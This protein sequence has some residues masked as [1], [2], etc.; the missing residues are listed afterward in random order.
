MHELVANLHMHTRYSDGQLT[1]REIAQAALRSGLDV[2]VVTDHNVWVQ[3]PEDIY[4]DGERKVLLLV[5]EEIHN[6]ALNPQKNHLLVIGAEREL[7]TYA[8]T[9][10]ALLEAVNKANGLSF[11]AHLY[12]PAAPLFGE[13]DI[14]WVDWNIQG[15]TGI[16]LWNG[17]SEFKSL[18]KSRLH[19]LYY[20]YN[21]QRV[22]HA[23]ATQALQRWDELLQQGRLVVAIGGSDAHALPARLG[24]L[25]KTLFPYEFHFRAINTHILTPNPL[26]GDL[27]QDRRMVLEA[28]R[29]GNAFI[30][31]DLPARTTG[32]RF[33]AQ[34]KDGTAQMGEA[35]SA[36]YGVTLSIRLPLATE[37]RLLRDG[38]VIK[39]WRKRQTCTYITTDPG[40]YRVEVYIHYLGRRRGWIFS[41]PIFV[42]K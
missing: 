42:C 16:E 24:P 37:C 33:I 26:S 36:Q 21:P 10:Q 4:R 14:S 20:A 30:G 18:L 19:A 32:F 1:H 17:M 7:A 28:L 41:N 38:K 34:G 15:F 8:D 11:L 35:I 5:G 31:Y 13:P 23:P 29:R 12:D 9:P 2:V 22:A 25:R 3:G 6:Q 39:V 40:V 27:E